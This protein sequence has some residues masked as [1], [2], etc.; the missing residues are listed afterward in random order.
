MQYIEHRYKNDPE[1]LAREK[2]EAIKK[3]GIPEMAGCLPLLMQI[4]M[5]I[6]LNRALSSSFELYQAPFFGWITD[7]SVKDPYYVLPLLGA[8]GM[9]IRTASAGD[10]RQRV[11]AMLIAIIVAAVTSSFAAGLTLYICVSTWIGLLQMYLQK[12]MK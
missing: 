5:F 6:G 3:Y 11:Q 7:L 10:P 2:A 12:A 1:A 9:V 8:L 4:P